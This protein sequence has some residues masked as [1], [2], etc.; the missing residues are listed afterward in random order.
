MLNANR[1][2]RRA[3]THWKVPSAYANEQPIKTGVAAAA[4]VLG[5]AA[6]IHALVEFVCTV[7][8]FND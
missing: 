8:I 6:N 1:K 4:N 3:G 7:P 2:Q 5:R